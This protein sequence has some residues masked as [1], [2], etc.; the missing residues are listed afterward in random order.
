MK[1]KSS[2]S[3]DI[4]KLCKVLKNLHDD[5]NRD[6]E[7]INMTEDTSLGKTI[8][9]NEDL[10]DIHKGKKENVTNIR[11]IIVIQRWWKD[12][13]YKKYL[14]DKIIIIQK[15]IRGYLFRKQI[16]QR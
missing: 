7:G 1:F 15:N 13:I 12:F 3:T 2:R 10:M 5:N 11:K 6:K 16:L 4:V 14:K 9:L 8:N